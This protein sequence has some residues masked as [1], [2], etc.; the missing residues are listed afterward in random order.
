MSVIDFFVPGPRH[1]D[2]SYYQNNH[3][4][5]A[6]IS[7]TGSACQC[8]CD[9]CEGKLLAS[10]TAAVTPAELVKIGNKLVKQG[11]QGV[12]ISGGADKKGSVPLAG[13]GGAL[14]ELRQLGLRVVVHPGLLSKTTAEV[15][16]SAAVDCVA[17]D[18]IGD[19]QTIASVYHLN[20][21]PADYRRSLH[22]ARTYGLNVSPHIVVGLNYG[23]MGGEY[24][25]INM[26][27]QEG[28]DCLV[29]VILKPLPGTAMGHCTPPPVQTVEALFRKARA[30]LPNTPILLGCA[31]PIGD[32]A[33]R[34]EKL[35]INV[36][37]SGMAFPS[38]ETVEY[39]ISQGLDTQ[40]HEICC[41]IW[42]DR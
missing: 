30:L 28:A 41:G 26:V 18:L 32:Y 34:V 14:I 31:R 21:H 17:L 40:Y 6:N 27:V 13:F 35:A 7:I 8:G 24:E 37:F 38:Q 36:G 2:T 4:S 22:I 39:A 23:R 11:C 9:H 10:M 3:R 19:E 5:F 15:L 12:L 33:R 42:C 1:Y 25:A 29:L 20:C 16:A